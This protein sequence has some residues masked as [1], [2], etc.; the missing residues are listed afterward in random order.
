MTGKRGHIGKNKHSQVWVETVIYTLIGLTIMGAIIGVVTPKITQMNDKILLTQTIDTMN[1]LN[2]Q[3]QDTYLYPGSQREVTLM[4]KKGEYTIDGA[5]DQIQF[6][7]K[8]TGLLY[9]Q[10]NITIRQGDLNILTVEKLGG[11]KYDIFLTLDYGDS[12]LTYQG[13]DQNKSLTSAPIAYRLLV[14]NNGIVSG[15]PKKNI[16]IKLTSG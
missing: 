11:K 8:N 14:I 4:V 3:V 6:L 10:P 1:Q 15:S 7:L 5:G 16:D 12:N 13:R 9:S 2:A